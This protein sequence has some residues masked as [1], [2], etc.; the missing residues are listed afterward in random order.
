MGIVYANSS[1]LIDNMWKVTDTTLRAIMNDSEKGKTKFDEFVSAVYNEDKSKKYAE[2]TAAMTE[3]GNMP[4]VEE[5]EVAPNDSLQEDYSSLIVHQKISLSFS[6]TDVSIEDAEDKTNFK[7][8]KNFVKSHKRSRAEI[9]HLALTSEGTTYSYEGKTVT[10]KTGDGLGLFST[11][12]SSMLDGVSTQSN[13]F[14]N[15]FGSDAVMLYTLANKG[16]NFLNASGHVQAYDFD[17]IIIPADCPAM[18]DL[19][20][21]IIGSNQIVGSGYNDINTQKNKWKLVVDPLWNTYGLSNPYILMSSEA[22]EDLDG[23][24]FYDRRP[25]TVRTSQNIHSGNLEYNG[26]A[27][28]G[29]GFNNWRHLI[30]G[31]AT[32]G[33]TIS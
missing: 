20:S 26:S 17:T 28:V 19:I 21:R 32:A 8:A 10:R 31:G 3:F 11:A 6:C 27:R 9:A 23:S 5:G 30:M 18:Q 4:I 22:N 33:S 15:A 29:V 16:K 14:T 2:K 13:V 1:G 12:H 7:K 25:L 24:M